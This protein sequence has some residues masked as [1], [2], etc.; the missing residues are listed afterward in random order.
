VFHRPIC[1]ACEV[2]MRPVCNDIVVVDYAGKPPQPYQLWSADEW[3]CPKCGH[4]IIRGFGDAPLIRHFED[5]FGKAIEKIPAE[6]RRNNFEYR[7]PIQD[8]P[9]AGRNTTIHVLFVPPR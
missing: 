5:S 7:E 4:R 8:V 3:G 6:L 2:E 1:C 9:D